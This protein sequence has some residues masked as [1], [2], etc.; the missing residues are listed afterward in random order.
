MPRKAHPDPWDA[1]PKWYW[2]VYCEDPVSFFFEAL[3]WIN[4]GCFEMAAERLWQAD[5]DGE[6]FDE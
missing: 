2:D 4:Y 3:S 5:L 1:H 6:A